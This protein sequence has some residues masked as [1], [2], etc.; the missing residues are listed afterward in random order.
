LFDIRLFRIAGMDKLCGEEFWN[1]GTEWI[2]NR[3]WIGG[4]VWLVLLAGAWCSA[5]GEKPAKHKPNRL[6]QES[7]PYLQLHA[8]NPVDWYPWGPEALEKAKAENKPIFLSIGYTSCYWCHV[9]ERQVFEN[10]AIAAYMNEH[11]INIK[12]DREERPDIDELYMLS[13]QVYLQLAGSN[14]GGGWP[15]SMFLTP[16]GKPIAGGTYYPP[17]DLPGRP[18]FLTVLKSVETAWRTRQKDVISTSDMIV[19]EVKRLSTPALVLT[20]IELNATLVAKA[21][22]AVSAAH[23]P[24]F[25][26]FDFS[27]Q[28]PD[29]PKFPIPS[30]LELLQTVGPFAEQAPE[31]LRQLDQ[32]LTLMEQGGIR[33]HL[34]GGF[35]RYSTDRHWLVPHFEKM[36]YD[37][38]QLA[39]V[40]TRAY[41]RTSQKNYRQVAEGTLDFLLRDMLDASGAFHSALDAE[42]DGVEGKYYVWSPNEVAQ[43]LTESELPIAERVY[44]LDQKSTFEVGSVLHLPKSIPD[45]AEALNLPVAELESKLGK[46]RDKLLTARQS[47]PALLKD[48][49][50][51]TS[52]NGMAIQALAEAGQAF[53]K[54]EY[55][56]GAKRAATMLLEKLKSEDGK[57]LHMY[58]GGVAK[59]PA[60][61][62]D[63]AALVAGLLAL[64]QST[65]DKRWLEE[66]RRL[67]DEMILQCADPRGGFFINSIRHEVLIARSKNAY[68]SVVPSGNSQAVRN[69]VRLAK[70]TGDNRYRDVARKTLEAFG[71]QF[72]QN[73]A[74]HA[75]LAIGLAEYL[76]AFGT[77]EAGGN[78][79]AALPKP[80]QPM[81]PAPTTDTPAA[82]EKLAVFAQPTA[83]VAAEHPLVTIE[84]AI[85]AGQFRAG[86][87]CPVEVTLKIQ[88]GWHINAN[89]A[90][91]KF[92]KPTDLKAKFASGAT[93]GT[94]TYPQGNDLASEGIDEP[95][96]VYEGTVVLKTTI[97]LPADFTATE[98][99]V[100]FTLQYQACNEQ[101]C[102][103]PVKVNFSGQVAV[104]K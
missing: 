13:L 65:E 48:D 12:V 18:G 70:L 76:A 69:L 92:L 30:R 62:E 83:E 10:E 36:L 103:A 23:D 20:P 6:A 94:V 19:K 55:T 41:V 27:S 58:R 34:G 79:L 91:P 101:A 84:A 98:E 75:F 56:E 24:D 33:D 49:K 43:L 66:S 95:L 64:H 21:V 9:M 42:S 80:G 45:A 46:I 22:E 100:S 93:L 72:E 87:K 31:L 81:P 38:A 97:D 73:P 50:I 74:G 32:T 90:R 96:S 54:H 16:D 35:H 89:P 47:R 1:A 26:G 37:N 51:L 59:G 60:Y 28:S 67:T 8:H 71:S 88:E 25:G 86:A 15:L 11:F 63:Y 68:D 77:L 78:P 104:A 14:Q 5:Q 61:L 17:E 57:L 99:T 102:K 85:A 40:Y 82:T 39:S 53:G 7:S 52:W 2:V 4:A 29:S 3:V 44:G